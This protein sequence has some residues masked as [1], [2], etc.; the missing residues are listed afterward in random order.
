MGELGEPGSVG[1]KIVRAALAAGLGTAVCNCSQKDHLSPQLVIH[2]EDC[3]Y[4]KAQ[5]RMRGCLHRELEENR[6]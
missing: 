2:D 3:D 1:R 6:P 5:D 4:G